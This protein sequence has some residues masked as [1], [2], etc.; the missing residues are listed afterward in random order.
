M[1]ELNF[2]KYLVLNFEWTRFGKSL[3]KNV[4]NSSAPLNSSIEIQS[5]E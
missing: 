5:L 1:W 4:Q 3:K 2:D